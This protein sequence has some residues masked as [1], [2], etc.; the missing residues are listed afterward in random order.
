MGGNL[1]LNVGPMSTGEIEDIQ[2][3]RLEAIGTFLKKNGE[4][5]YGTTGGIYN[6]TWGGTTLTDKAIYVHI[7]KA[8]ADGKISIPATNRKIASAVILHTNEKIRFKQTDSGIELL[9]LPE[10][11]NIADTIIKL[12]LK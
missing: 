12:S 9:S 8:S 4:S 10:N 3:Q 1:L 6:D 5:I 7:L 2:I 11:K